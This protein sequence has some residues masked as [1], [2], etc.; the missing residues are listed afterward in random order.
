MDK[1]MP[2]RKDSSLPGIMKAKYLDQFNAS[3]TQEEKE[4]ILRD[5]RSKMAKYP[6]FENIYKYKLSKKYV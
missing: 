1:F 4:R 2:S 6:L 3:A 5:N